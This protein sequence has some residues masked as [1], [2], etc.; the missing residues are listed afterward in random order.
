M[1]HDTTN[2]Y[3]DDLAIQRQLLLWVTATRR[4]LQRWEANVAAIVHF[5]LQSH[6]PSGRLVWEAEIE[7]HLAFVSARNLLRA[8]DLA[9]PHIRVDTGF[10]EMLR[11]VRD[12]LEHWDENMPVFNVHPQRRPAPR[13][14][15]KLFKAKNEGQTPYSAFAWNSIE[16]PLLIAGVPASMLHSLLDEVEAEVIRDRPEM[17]EFIPERVPSPWLGESAGEDQWL[18]RIAADRK[19]DPQR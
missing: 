7:R 8:I 13:R 18:P 9:Q 4:Q 12:L 11:V 14:S 17:I 6:E 10:E 19:A 3:F 1:N 5:G 2:D 15:G 16:G